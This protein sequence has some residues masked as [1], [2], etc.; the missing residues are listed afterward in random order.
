MRG[1]ACALRCVNAGRQ[2]QLAWTLGI[3]VVSSRFSHSS[4]ASHPANNHATVTDTSSK[5]LGV[6]ESPSRGLSVA[7]PTMAREKAGNQALKGVGQERG[8]PLRS[9]VGFLVIKIIIGID[10]ANWSV[11][12]WA[13]CFFPPRQ[14]H[15]PGWTLTSL[16]S[17]CCL[18]HTFEPTQP[19]LG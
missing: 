16:Q 12:H 15:L 5:M 17:R 3:P 10:K 13:A 8:S 4:R 2:P 11:F 19:G 6:E 18:S 1:L 14:A 9:R 7:D